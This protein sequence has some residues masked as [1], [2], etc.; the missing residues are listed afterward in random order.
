[1]RCCFRITIV[2]IL[3]DPDFGCVK[4]RLSILVYNQ[5]HVQ[6][7]CSVIDSTMSHACTVI[8]RLVISNA[9][10]QYCRSMCIVFILVIDSNSR[11]SCAE[12]DFCELYTW[13]YVI[14]FVLMMILVFAFELHYYG[15]I[16]SMNLLVRLEFWGPVTILNYPSYWRY[17]HTDLRLK[18]VSS[19]RAMRFTST[20]V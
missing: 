8:V 15:I 10:L 6:S 3:C 7:T 16:S 14:S 19:T 13:K 5:Y 12:I 9:L 17:L 20:I 18:Y 11:A 4:L 1:M 2:D